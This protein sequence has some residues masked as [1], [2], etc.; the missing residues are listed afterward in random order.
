M[1]ILDSCD[2]FPHK[3]RNSHCDD[4]SRVFGDLARV[5]VLVLAFVIASLRFS[6]AVTFFT[7]PA[8]HPQGTNLATDATLLVAHPA[9]CLLMGHSSLSKH[10]LTPQRRC[11]LSCANTDPHLHITLPKCVADAAGDVAQGSVPWL[12]QG[13]LS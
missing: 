2:P 12:S 5:R 8:D 13:L 9:R 11:R 10:T 6:C 4:V 1:G 7:L 3:C